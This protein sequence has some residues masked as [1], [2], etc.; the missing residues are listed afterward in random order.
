M[1]IQATLPNMGDVILSIQQK[2]MELTT[3]G[4]ILP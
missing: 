3:T 2:P 1:E 4:D